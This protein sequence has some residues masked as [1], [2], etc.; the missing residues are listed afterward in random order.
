M[1]L[2]ITFE[3]GQRRAAEQPP[4]SAMLAHPNRSMTILIAGIALLANL[5]QISSVSAQC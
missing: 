2:F 3:A 4:G 1:Y 5:A